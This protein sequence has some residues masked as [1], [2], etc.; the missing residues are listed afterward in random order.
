MATTSPLRRRMI[1]DMTV[2]NLS[3]A[4]QRSYI[5]AISKFSRYFGRSPDHLELEDVRAF[6]VH[7]VS[8]GISWPSLNQTVCALRFFYG[9]TLN[10]AMVP[11]RIPYAREP[12]K[13]PVVLSADEVILFLEAISSLKSRAALTT[14]YAAGLR[15]S[16]VATLRVADVDSG[17][18]IILVRH[19]KGG[20]DRN[21]MLS[22]QLL[23]ILRT[24]WRLAR[25]TV[26]LFPGRNEDHA[27]DPTVLHAAC[28]SA[29][30]AAGLTKRTLH[31]L[32]HSF[33]THLLENGTTSGSFRSCSAT[34][35]CRRRHAIRR[36]RPTPSGQRRARLIA[37]RWR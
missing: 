23:A 13:L 24:Y 36:W 14:A 8:T 5:S 22:A 16:E 2:R 30:K 28:R 18:R 6:Q 37:C 33:A 10:D 11:E 29:V 21:V 32:R 1:E 17:R 4:T 12:R 26:F 7:L 20:K 35:I 9:V 3:P 34:A 19:S 27:I 15:A 25:P 31:T